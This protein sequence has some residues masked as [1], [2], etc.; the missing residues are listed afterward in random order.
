MQVLEEFRNL[1]KQENR[2][3]LIVTHDAKV[4]RIADRVASIRDGRLCTHEVEE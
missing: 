2:A 4:R 3:L 1:A